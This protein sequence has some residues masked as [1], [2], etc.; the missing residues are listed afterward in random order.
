MALAKQCDI[1]GALYPHIHKVKNA[2]S[3]G[4]AYSDGMIDSNRVWWDACPDY[5]NAINEVI[6][7]RKGERKDD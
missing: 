6:D 3:I 4:H 7:K 5:I 2:L 1:C